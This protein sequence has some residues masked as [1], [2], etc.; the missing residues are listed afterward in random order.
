V[1]PYN[2]QEVKLC[3]TK[4]EIKRAAQEAVYICVIERYPARD[5]S[6]E[7]VKG[8]QAIPKQHKL[9]ASI[10]STGNTILPPVDGH[11]YAIKLEGDAVPP[12]GPIYPLAEAELEVL[13]AYINK[14][15]ANGRI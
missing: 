13:Q 2:L 10:F 8:L 3:F 1:F 4:K 11:M 14:A 12:V 5:P 7:P 15:L 9:Y 6:K